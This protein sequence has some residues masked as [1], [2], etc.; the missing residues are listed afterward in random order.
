MAR[1]T[2]LDTRV[3]GRLCFEVV[4]GNYPEVAAAAAGIVRS[5]FL[6]W[7]TDTART[8][9]Q[10]QDRIRGR[11]YAEYERRLENIEL[12]LKYLA[13]VP[14]ERQARRAGRRAQ[15]DRFGNPRP[16]QPE[17]LRPKTIAAWLAFS[18]TVARAE[19]LA[20][21]RDNKKI[22][23]SDDWKAAAFK[24]ERRAPRRW[25][26]RSRVE[27][28]DGEG[29]ALPTAPAA[30]VPLVVGH[31]PYNHR[32]PLPPDGTVQEGPYLPPANAGEDGDGAT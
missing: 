27:L 22:D 1:P 25:G 12:W 10:L 14:D 3:A 16:E 20:E 4:M 15:L 21:I 28:T 13:W 30:M 17:T 23:R 7:L 8:D 2:K 24:L 11:P 18:D 6:K 9:P 26:Q 32:D 19:A 29:N 5:T 31:L